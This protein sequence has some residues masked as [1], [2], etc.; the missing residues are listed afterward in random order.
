MATITPT[1]TPKPG[2]CVQTLW[3]T[4]TESD[5]AAVLE[6]PGASDRTVHF[7]G[8]WG[9]ATGVLQ[10]TLDGTNFFTCHDGVGAEISMTTNGVAF[11]AE[12][13]LQYRPSFS[14]G[15]GQDVDV[16]MFCHSSHY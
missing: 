10:G 9:S 14:G 16:L 15:S 1:N 6:L 4:V 11:V 7:Y 5:S 8:T 2:G 13:C 12:N 3:E